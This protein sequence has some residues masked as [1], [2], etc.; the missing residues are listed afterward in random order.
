MCRAVPIIEIS[1]NRNSFGIRCPYGK[2]NT[3]LSINDRLVG[4]Q[5][6]IGPQ[7]RPLAEQMQIQVA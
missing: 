7:V 4:P 2:V 1:N 5:L 3:L 6:F